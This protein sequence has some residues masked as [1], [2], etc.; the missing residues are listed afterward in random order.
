METIIPQNTIENSTTEYITQTENNTPTEYI[1]QTQYNASIEHNKITEMIKS[2]EMN[3]ENN[4]NTS[5]LCPIENYTKGKIIAT[6]PP[7]TTTVNIQNNQMNQMNPMMYQNNQMNPMMYQNNMMSQQ[8][9]QVQVTKLPLKMK[10]GNSVMEPVIEL[11][12][13]KCNVYLKK[14]KS[15]GAKDKWNVVIEITD[16]EMQAKFDEINQ[17]I[18]EACFKYKNMLCPNGQNITDI[19]NIQ[20][21]DIIWYRRTPEGQLLENEPPLHIAGFNRES[22][23]QMYI[24]D[25]ENKFVSIEY[26][27]LSGYKLTAGISIVIPTVWKGIGVLY[28]QSYIRKLVV[29]DCDKNGEINVESTK[30]LSK[31]IQ[32]NKFDNNHMSH[33]ISKF[34]VKEEDKNMNMNI[35]INKENEHLQQEQMNKPENIVIPN[36]AH[37]DISIPNSN[38]P[39]MGQNYPQTMNLNIPNTSIPNT[40]IPNTNNLNTGY[41]SLPNVT[42]NGGYTSNPMS[43]PMG[44]NISNVPMTMY[45]TI[46][47]D[48]RS[49]L[50]N[51]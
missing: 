4:Y 10:N 35:N 51:N 1:T 41:M 11:K 23:V 34:T 8:T 29:L 14:Q 19:N 33:L 12:I 28:P 37:V 26:K 50:Q 3:N 30:Y 22:I 45:N 32:N 9:Q 24:P 5:R 43:I 17:D 48:A 16:P 7:V 2:S 44:G 42:S 31:Y 46:Q 36:P 40:N 38:I 39:M 21:K 20:M 18:K 49:Y 6:G 27:N 15:P 47:Q 13:S 25:G